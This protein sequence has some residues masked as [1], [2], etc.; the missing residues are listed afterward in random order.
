[1]K[2]TDRKAVVTHLMTSKRW[3]EME[4]W[5]KK[6]LDDSTN[7]E[8]YEKAGMPACTGA[9]YA[10]HH[11]GFLVKHGDAKPFIDDKQRFIT[12]FPKEFSDWISNGCFG[13]SDPLAPAMS[14]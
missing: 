14:A 1:M 8:S 13:L 9:L 6:S 4:A 11:L 7:P 3:S 12:P 10:L 2:N 5:L